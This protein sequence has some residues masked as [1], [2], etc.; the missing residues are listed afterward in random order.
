M[1]TTTIIATITIGNDEQTRSGS[2]WACSTE[3]GRHE[4]S[5]GSARTPRNNRSAR[6]W[7]A[8]AQRVMRGM[9]IRWSEAEYRAAGYSQGGDHAQ[10]G[11]RITVPM[12]VRR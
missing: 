7:F 1:A 10:D 6:A 11:I 5:G 2:S 12:R 4:F 9:G 8:Y 3:D